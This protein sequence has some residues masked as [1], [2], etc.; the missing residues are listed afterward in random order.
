[1]LERVKIFFCRESLKQLEKEVN[2]FLEATNGEF[3]AI[4]YNTILAT[5]EWGTG[6]LLTYL[7][8]IKVDKQIR[9]IEKENKKEGKALK[10]LEKADKK[11]DKVCEYGE[12]MMKKKERKK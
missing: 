10:D 11:R 3:V 1:M 4:E 8:E 12:K 7:P 5:E 9:K 2:V 6:I